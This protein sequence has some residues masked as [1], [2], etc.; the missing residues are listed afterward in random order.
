MIAPYVIAVVDE[1]ISIQVSAD[2]SILQDIMEIGFSHPLLLPRWK[3]TKNVHYTHDN[4]TKL[5]DG[6]TKYR[7]CS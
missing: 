2:A 7:K 4:L 1:S 3:A 6:L 5:V